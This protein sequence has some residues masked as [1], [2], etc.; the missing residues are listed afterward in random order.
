M[1][2][3]RNR[4]EGSNDPRWCGGKHHIRLDTMTR[5]KETRK[6]NSGGLIVRGARQRRLLD[7]RRPMSPGVVSVENL[8]EDRERDVH[9]QQDDGDRMSE[10]WG[11]DTSTTSFTGKSSS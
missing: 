7:R 1:G 3:L 2:E 9:R 10:S 6:A 11:H 8:D 4:D 5:A